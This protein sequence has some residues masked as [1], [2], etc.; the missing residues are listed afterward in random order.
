MSVL[1]ACAMADYREKL[2]ALLERLTGKRDVTDME[3]RQ[4]DTD[5]KIEDL[6]LKKARGAIR[7]M[8]QES[9]VLPSETERRIE[10]AICAPLP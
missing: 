10:E 8:N 7:L 3:Y 6:D 9:V 4:V 2:L 1:N 5:T